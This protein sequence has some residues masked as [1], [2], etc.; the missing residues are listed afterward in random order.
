VFEENLK[1]PILKN[2]VKY[3][4]KHLN[5]VSED[6]KTQ[7]IYSVILFT[8]YV[9]NVSLFSQFYIINWFNREKNLLKDVSQQVKYTAVEETLHAQIGI[10]IINTIR[11]EAP[12]LF[13]EALE[14]L[15]LKEAKDA[16]KAEEAIIDWMLGDYSGK[17]LDKELLKNYIRNRLNESLNQIGYQSI[18]EVDQERLLEKFIRL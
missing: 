11:E 17:N 10:K 6:D 18:F 4:T 16:L 14:K 5:K 9:E 13:T 1:L 2:R 12:E 8:L 3:L 7:F 15:I